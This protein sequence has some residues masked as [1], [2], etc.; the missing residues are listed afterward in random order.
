M[1]LFETSR[2]PRIASRLLPAVAAVV[3][4]TMSALPSNPQE[5]TNPVGTINGMP[6]TMQD[7]DYAVNDLGDQLGQVPPEQR[8]IAALM[9]LIDI[10]LLAEKAAAEKLDETEEFKQRMAFLRDRALHNSIFKKDVIDT[11]TEAEVRTRY[12]AE[13]ANTPAENEVR[14]RHILLK[15]QEEAVEVIKT[16]DGGADFAELA[17]EKSTGPT[18]PN[19]GGYPWSRQP[20]SA[21]EVVFPIR[22]QG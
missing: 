2:L 3:L 13:I 15:T 5:A 18:G 7:L 16:L 21:D 14:A 1:S 8:K 22:Q 9:A 6:I 11:I 4:G 20:R 12:D 19:P 10:K 17:K